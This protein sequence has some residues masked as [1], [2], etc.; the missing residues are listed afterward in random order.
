MIP[1]QQRAI[2]INVISPDQHF[3][4]AMAEFDELVRFMALLKHENFHELLVEIRKR[5]PTLCS[6]SSMD[7]T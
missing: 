2:L 4:Q 6:C 3:T 7:R 1:L 5:I